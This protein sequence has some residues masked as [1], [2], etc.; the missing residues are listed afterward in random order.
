MFIEYIMSPHT[1]F[2]AAYFKWQSQVPGG[3]IF[4]ERLC[5]IS[6]PYC[7]IMMWLIIMV[8][9]IIDS[10]CMI[11]V[12]IIRS[13]SSNEVVKL[14]IACCVVITSSHSVE[15]TPLQLFQ[16]FLRQPFL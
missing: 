8:I 5:I 4:C 7:C 14:F 15:E 11:N 12:V 10:N 1:V 3:N 9:C 6:L 13:L 16:Y 2:Y